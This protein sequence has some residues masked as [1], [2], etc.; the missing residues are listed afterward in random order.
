[1]TE[2]RIRDEFDDRAQLLGEVAFDETTLDQ[3]IPLLSRWGVADRDGND[4]TEMIGQ[5][6]VTDSG[7]YF[8][9]VLV[10]PDE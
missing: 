4:R 6:K 9:V 2:V 7:A 8:E 10:G 1:M 3:V 5:F